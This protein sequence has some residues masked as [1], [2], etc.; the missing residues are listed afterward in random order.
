MDATAGYDLIAGLQVGQELLM[1]LLSF[2]LGSNQKEIK[3]HT[4]E[5][6]REQR[7]Q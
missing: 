6:K 7:L 2:L 4:H 5:Q 1:L 3:Q